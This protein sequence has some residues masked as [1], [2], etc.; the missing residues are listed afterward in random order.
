MQF[1]AAHGPCAPS[2]AWRVVDAK[3]AFD[4]ALSPGA[5]PYEGADKS[6]D[7]PAIIGIGGSL[8]YF[9][10]PLRQEGLGLRRGVR[11]ARRAR[12]AAEGVGFYFLDHLTHNVY[13]GHMDKWWDFYA[14]LFNFQQIRFFDIEGKLTGCTRAR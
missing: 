14:R 6:L 5:E 7:V 10:G 8:L 9:V 3:H 4:H 1:V 13:R 12:P 2:M 11:V